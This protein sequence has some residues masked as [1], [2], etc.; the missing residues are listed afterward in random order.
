M[1][2]LRMPILFI[3]Y[4]QEEEISPQRHRGRGEEDLK[5]RREEEI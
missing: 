2:W 5:G 1:G 4:L 3:I